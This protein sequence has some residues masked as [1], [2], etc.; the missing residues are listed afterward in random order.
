MSK[1]ATAWICSSVRQET[2]ACPGGTCSSATPVAEATV[3]RVR[4]VLLPAIGSMLLLSTT[5]QITQSVA[6]LPLVWVATLALYLL[7]FILCFER[8]ALARRSVWIPVWT[9]A[10]L[11]IALFAVLWLRNRPARGGADAHGLA[12]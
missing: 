11:A 9:L 12:R 10:L 7:S 3:H 5:T 8:E 6:P 2:S 4:W 1:R